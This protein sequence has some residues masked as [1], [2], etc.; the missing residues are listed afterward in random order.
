MQEILSKRMADLTVLEV[1]EF[2]FLNSLMNSPTMTITEFCKAT[3]KTRRRVNKLLSNRL[4]PESL[5]IGGYESRKQNTAVMFDT[6][7]VIKYLK[8]DGTP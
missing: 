8:N 7:E 3:G 5:I 4:L 2:T 1:M 6:E